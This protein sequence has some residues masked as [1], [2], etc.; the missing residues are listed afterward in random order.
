MAHRFAVSPS[1]GTSIIVA[2]VEEAG[3]RARGSLVDAER[4]R[5]E[6]SAGVGERYELRRELGRGGMGVVYEAFDRV[7][8]TRVALKTMRRLDALALY[9]FK[10]E[11]RALAD[12]SH[13]NLAS[14]YELEAEGGVT[15]FTME[16][17][18]G[19]DFLRYVTADATF[20]AGLDITLPATPTSDERERADARNASHSPS[21]MVTCD[22]LRLRSTL[23]Q[24]VEGVAALHASGKVHRDL[25]PSNVLV[26]SS[27]DA[28]V[29]VLDFGLATTI[30]CEA[31]ETN[32]SLVGTPEYM[33]PEQ[34][35]ADPPTEASDWYSVGVILYEALV[36]ALPFTGPPLKLVQVKQQA[37]PRRPREVVGGVP[38]DLD[39]LC[40]DLL[41]R[42]PA[43]RPNA[44]AIR[45]RLGR[46]APAERTPRA[47]VEQTRPTL[48]A[49][50]IGRE[51]HMRALVDA[52]EATKRGRAVVAYVHGSSGMG[53]SVLVKRFLETL[54]ASADAVVLTGRCYERESVP[55]KALDSVVDALS[56]YLA[57]QKRH[58]VEALLPLGIHALTRVFPVLDRVEAVSA[59]PRRPYEAP[60]PLE[61]RRRAA[62]A[63]RE[64]VE[65]MTWGRPLVIWIDDLQWGDIDSAAL[66]YEL[67]RPPEP[68]AVLLV[69]SY[70]SEDASSPLVSAMR[71]MH[72]R[73]SVA[74]TCEVEVGPL[75]RDEACEL[76]RALGADAAAA[77][78]VADESR[79]NPLFVDELV[80]HLRTGVSL[81]ASGAGSE[82]RLD[83]VL[84]ARVSAL[85]AEPKRLL[86]VIALAGRPFPR[87]ALSSAAELESERTISALGVLRSGRLVRAIKSR[88]LDD[89]ETY[90]D[91]IR[92]TVVAHLDESARAVLHLRLA[93]ALVA[94]GNADDETLV[95]HFR[96]AGELRRAA[97]HAATAAAKAVAGL[98]FDRAAALFRSALEAPGISVE[99]ARELRWKLG[100]ALANAGR[101]AEAADAYHA[102][103]EGASASDALELRRLA[104][105]Q[106][107][108]SGR[109]AEGMRAIQ[110]VLA[111]VGMKLPTSPWLVLVSVVFHELLLRL[112]GLRFREREAS[113]LPERELR[114][115]DVCWSVGSTLAIVQP[116][117]A[118]IFQKKHLLLALRAGEPTRIAR[119]F[120]LEGPSS[121]QGGVP[122][123]VRTQKLSRAAHEVATRLGE[124]YAMT[125]AKA[126]DGLI[127]YV[128]GRFRDA[129]EL[130][131]VA[132]QQFRDRCSGAVWHL[133]TIALYTSW[134][135]F[136]L[137]EMAELT[138]RMPQL[139]LEAR[140]RGDLYLLTNMRIGLLNAIWLAADDVE[141]AERELDDAM[142]QW[143]SPEQQLQHYH[144]L[145]ARV[146]VGLY[147]G[148]A[149][150][151]LALFEDRWPSIARAQLGRVQVLRV[152]LLHLHARAAVGAASELDAPLA[153]RLDRS[154]LRAARKILRE[155][156]RWSSP[157]AR[158]I[159]A[160][161]HARRGERARAI[162]LL[163][164]AIEDFDASD[165]ALWAAA[166]RRRRGELLGG[167]E[168]G[169]LADA[170]D[171][172]FH[173]KGVENPESYCRMLAPGFPA[174]DRAR[175]RSPAASHATSTTS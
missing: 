161:V 142:A 156:L 157:L 90:H 106:L 114:R 11:F 128:E 57:R 167:D 78:L 7:R 15:F 175:P 14:L 131:D 160:A 121:A 168:G 83:D 125:F 150:A 25:K 116:I 89:V 20:T 49:A 86:E 17:V 102:A 1:T 108:R 75:V 44:D 40:M 79:G 21:E 61:L 50:F 166:A 118:K 37:D 133:E 84:H 141:R 143:G 56:R 152:Q 59:A 58:D 99:Y 54:T 33:S 129:L 120:T 100:D 35:A 109:I 45:D 123:R 5:L 113:D 91:R 119:G 124:P 101:G 98:A 154:A 19:V 85:P 107:L 71:E 9:R 53:K 23:G 164:S 117:P 46:A 62:T 60:D 153:R 81:H 96:E 137:G 64:L 122:A 69:V 41:H 159:E 138:K 73:D 93:L 38:D 149:G 12:V 74:V 171:A 65:R 111:A 155:R 77:T 174:R 127:A 172:T 8:G 43:R 173:E 148:R 130:G 144:E 34:A 24:L 94:S 140:Q 70:R 47:N 82:L 136:H 6:G 52:F 10:A 145:F 26:T 158:L 126:A 105:E 163:A 36:G 18:E 3:E 146:Q 170:A 29:V 112:R 135:L 92:E 39:A 28:R 22:I 169:A 13:R 76:A 132:S 32:D 63:L 97:E 66:I 103:V 30:G 4:A 27:A 68:P 104:A 95:V 55:Y 67:L 48:G 2:M 134:A 151:A 162:G 87:A 115:I 139:A 31:G 80:Q 42:D 16:Y 88:E 165:M 72:A 147:C 110:H 51:R